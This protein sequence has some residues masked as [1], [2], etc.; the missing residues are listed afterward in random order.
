MYHPKAQQ[1]P[2]A[3]CHAART[4]RGGGNIYISPAPRRWWEASSFESVLKSS[5]EGARETLSL[6]TSLPLLKF[7]GLI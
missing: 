1:S 7:G 3:T 2:L 4:S 6:I 5:T